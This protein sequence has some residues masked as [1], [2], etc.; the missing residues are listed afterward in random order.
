VLIGFG[1]ID[2]SDRLFTPVSEQLPM[3]GVEINAN[4]LDMLLS[5][6]SLRH[7]AIGL[8]FLAL[9]LVSMTSIWLVLRYPGA[10]GLILLAGMLVAGYVIA[11]LLFA[12]YH[13]LLSFGPLLAAGVLAAPIAQLENLLLVNRE[14]TSR[15]QHLRRTMMPAAETLPSDNLDQAT[16]AAATP[17][18]SGLH[19]KLAALKQLQADLSSLYRFRQTLLETMR[20]GLAVYGADGALLFSNGTWQEFCRRH[21]A[22]LDAKTQVAALAGGWPELA[23][24]AQD[25][26]AWVEHEVSLGEELWLFRAVR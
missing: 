6:R 20:E 8:Q 1:A 10:R 5:G 16:N 24:L 3:P 25:G 14:V 12:Q 4:V 9:L 11:Y 22:Q 26:S 2:V 19:W 21:G 18:P 15:L 23:T 7:L 13:L 17:A